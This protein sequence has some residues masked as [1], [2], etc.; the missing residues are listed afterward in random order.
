MSLKTLVFCVCVTLASAAIQRSALEPIPDKFSGLQGCYIR[1]FDGVLPFDSVTYS[2]EAECTRYFCAHDAVIHQSCKDEL[3][4]DT[5][6]CTFTKT[7][8]KRD[9]ICIL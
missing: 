3:S 7:E 9:T 4:T 5:P 2:K 1:E 6:V 8:E